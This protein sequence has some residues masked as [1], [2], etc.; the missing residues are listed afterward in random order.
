MK[1]NLK[2]L[3]TIPSLSACDGIANYAMSYYRR[4]NHECFHIDF[5]IHVNEG[6]F[7]KEVEDNKDQVYVMK[8]PN[9]KNT[10][11][12]LKAVKDFFEKHHDYDIIHCHVPNMATFYLYYA[13]KYGIA[14]RILHSHVTRSADVLSSKIRNDLLA[15]FAVSMANH[16][17]ACT[18]AA[19]KFLFDDKNFEI[20]N[21]AIDLKKFEFSKETRRKKREELSCGNQYV[22]GFVGRFCNQKNPLFLI[23]IFEEMYRVRQDLILLMI[24][25]GPL[26]RK[27]RTAI[28]E[29]KLEH[30]VIMKEKQTDISPFY[31]AM[32]AFVLPSR[33]EGLGIVYIEAQVSGLPT[34]ASTEVP[35]DTNISPTMKYI[36]L[37]E[38][39]TV[40]AEE[41]L[42]AFPSDNRKSHVEEGRRCGFDI[43]ERVDYLE[44]YYKQ[45]LNS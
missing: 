9:L 8:E 36:G 44:K 26:E 39:K 25:E 23:D 12:F 27:I 34:F 29:K 42:K 32:D 2:I 3:Y 24:G 38:K 16:Y 43:E 19:G 1:E 6:E 7:I 18:K 13:K 40:W 28:T 21:N 31:Q 45:L 33:Y 35:K 11:G 41:I 15:P 20:I 30:A 22:I 37:K 5:L 10:G 17:A 14:I 4:L